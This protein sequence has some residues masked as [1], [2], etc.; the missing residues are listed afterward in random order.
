MK[1]SPPPGHPC[2]AAQSDRSTR[3]S[4]RQAAAT[5]TAV[6]NSDRL[7]NNHTVTD[8]DDTDS[9]GDW[10]VG[11]GNLVI[12]LDADLERHQ[13]ATS[14]SGPVSPNITSSKMSSVEHHAVV[15]NGLKMKIKRK[16]IGSKTSDV[17]HEI[18]KN[19]DGK[20]ASGNNSTVDNT[21]TSMPGSVP[22]SPMDKQKHGAP[23]D[24]EK[25]TKGRAAHKK[26]KTRAK[27]MEPISNGSPF[28]SSPGSISSSGPSGSSTNSTSIPN[29]AL[30]H[31]VSVE[32][33]RISTLPFNIKKETPAEDPY[34]F[35]AKVEDGG[36]PLS[37]PK[38]VKVEKVSF[39]KSSENLMP[40]VPM[41]WRVV[42]TF[43][44][45]MSLTVDLCLTVEYFTLL[46]LVVTSH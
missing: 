39:I 10:D 2:V 9:D 27:G 42:L 45:V 38:K 7:N 11:V 14:V 31:R 21:G 6:T 30:V 15:D 46:A 33:D 25:A 37:F 32:L 40:V 44:T 12:D 8:H 43:L 4:T 1:E 35:N 19:P 34:E 3:G 29:T 18:V 36:R 41:R 17:K 16:N 26:D 24:K 5:T 22:N 20:A 28:L 23:S 13:K